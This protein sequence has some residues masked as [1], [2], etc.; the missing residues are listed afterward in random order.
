MA[1]INYSNKDLYPYGKEG[2][3]GGQTINSTV[4]TPV[5]PLPVQY[6]NPEIVPDI[7]G[8]DSELPELTKPET[9]ASDLTKRLRGLYGQTVGESSY[10][11]S[12]EVAQGVPEAQKVQTDLSVQLKQL[13]AEAKAIPIQLQQQA[14][15]RG[16]TAG[17]LAPIQTAKLR[18]NAIKALTVSSLLEASRGNL[19]TAQSLVDRAVAAKYDPIKE[20]INAN[21]KNLEL[22]LNSPEYTVAE[23]NR[24]EIQKNLQR[25]KERQVAKDEQDDKDVRNLSLTA[26]KYGAPSDVIQK[27]QEAGSFDEAQLIAGSYLRDPQAKYELEAARLDNILKK[28]Q[29][30]KV[31]KETRL[32][33]E[34]TEKETKEMKEAL[35]EAES[36]IPVMQDKIDAVDTLSIHSG[37]DTR[38]GPNFLTRGPRGFFGGLGRVVSGVGIPTVIGSAYTE[39]TGKG[40]DFAGGI[41]KL[42]GGLTLDSLIAA[43][44]R[45]ATFGALSDSELKIL[46][47]SA[48]AISDWEIKD[49]NNRGTGFWNIDQE[50]FKR[51]LKTVQDL[52]RRALIQSQGKIFTEDEDILLNTVFNEESFDPNNY[53]K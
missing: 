2:L 24:A 31:Q 35:M 27:I 7:S 14:E 9:E 37:F 23:K 4:L 44:A 42:V 15:G 34:P 5:A 21:L 33:G 32:L 43:K 41:H 13:V 30:D 20:E 17:G 50:S 38:V 29:I 51:E 49:K 25:E 48:T 8:L 18:E 22:I 1:E 26:Q 28:A 39:L 6:P 45:G 46:A 36:S 52:T 12:Q 3:V 40:Q 11:A 53:F 16:I 19:A 47:N 10:R